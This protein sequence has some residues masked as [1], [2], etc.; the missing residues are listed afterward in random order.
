MY[1]T[2]CIGSYIFSNR[3]TGTYIFA[4]PRDFELQVARKTRNSRPRASR[5]IGRL[6][7]F[8]LDA[9]IPIIEVNC[10]AHRTSERSNFQI[11]NLEVGSTSSTYSYRIPKLS[12]RYLPNRSKPH[13]SLSLRQIWRPPR[14]GIWR[15]RFLTNRGVNKF[16]TSDCAGIGRVNFD[17]I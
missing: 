16:D 2:R 8:L 6:A 15:S 12:F 10:I 5:N 3:Y 7:E 17:F 4:T 11:W 9:E 14:P 1:V 13:F